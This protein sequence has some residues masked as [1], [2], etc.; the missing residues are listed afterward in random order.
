MDLQA[1]KDLNGGLWLFAKIGVV[2]CFGLA[3]LLLAS[4]L[5]TPAKVRADILGSSLV[6]LP[7]SPV[8]LSLSSASHSIRPPG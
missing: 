3:G 4:S 7:L 1:A 6:Q 2:F 8:S 5:W